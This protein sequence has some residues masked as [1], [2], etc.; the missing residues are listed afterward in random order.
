MTELLI[1]NP[2]VKTFTLFIFGFVLGWL[3][4]VAERSIKHDQAS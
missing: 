2:W 3:T 4:G 1:T